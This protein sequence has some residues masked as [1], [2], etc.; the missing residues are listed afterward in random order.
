VV[1]PEVLLMDEPFSA[2]DVLTADNLRSDL[3]DLWQSKKANIKSILFVTHNIEEAVLLAD[4]IFIFGINPGHIRAELQVTLPQPRNDQDR[5]FRQLVD[6]IYTLMTTPTLPTAAAPIVDAA[7]KYKAIDMG[8]RLPTVAISELIGLIE[9]LNAPEYKDKERIDL[10]ELADALHLN[11]DDLFPI[12]ESLEVLRFARVSSGDI[13]LS[14]AGKQF[15][16]ADILEQK[17]IFAT[18]LINYLPLARH[19]RRVLDER[20]NHQA[21]EERFLRELEDYL[22]ADAAEEVLKTMIDWGRY[23]ELF[24]YDYNTGNLSLENP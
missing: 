9:T 2:L 17:K 23:A 1:N 24:A 20:R 18:H 7:M 11:V 5:Q 16:N 6:Q 3:L 12:T 15:A 4:R 13:E 10:P 8:Y 19:I 21:S 14:P 22:T